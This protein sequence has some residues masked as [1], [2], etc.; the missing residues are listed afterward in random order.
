MFFTYN[1]STIHYRRGGYGNKTLLCF[2]G[3]GETSA[4]FNFLEKTLA[5]EFTVISID[6]PFHGQTNWLD[7]RISPEDL[8][9]APANLHL[10]G[11][12]MGAR[13]ALC[14]MQQMPE[15]IGKLV[16]LAPD[17]LTVN[18]WYW[19]STQTFIGNRLFRLTMS[20][21]GWFLGM[22]HAGNRLRIINQSIYKFVTYYIHDDAVR[23]ALYQRWTGFSK[24][25]PSISSIRRTLLKYPIPV[26]LLY[27]KYDRIIGDR[28]GRKF[29]KDIPGARI[30]LIDCGHQ[31]L[32]EKNAAA[33]ANALLD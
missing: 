29:L 10:L 23:K 21:P 14:V 19:L 31:V 13:L 9:L 3:Y 8:Q 25:A 20:K 18:F 24:C 1:R 7:A 17:G 2:H 4:N 32:H 26:R 15:S 12:S 30:E 22:L 33:I 11:F 27:G 16:L 28:R 5:D 6:L